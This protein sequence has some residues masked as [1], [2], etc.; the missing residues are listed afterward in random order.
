MRIHSVVTKE[1]SIPR[2]ECFMEAEESFDVF[3]PEVQVS[4]V[5]EST[6]KT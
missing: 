6:L 5:S 2:F 4:F 1:R 3:G